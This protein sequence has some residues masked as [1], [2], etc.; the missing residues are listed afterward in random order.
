M[1]YDNLDLRLYDYLRLRPF[2]YTMPMIGV[3]WSMSRVHFHAH[4]AF[5]TTV[6]K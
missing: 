5:F 1:T 3:R 4:R 2:L 6:W